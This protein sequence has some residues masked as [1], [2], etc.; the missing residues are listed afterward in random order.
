MTSHAL[1]AERIKSSATVISWL[2]IITLFAVGLAKLGL[3]DPVELQIA[4]AARQW[5]KGSGIGVGRDGFYAFILSYFF[6]WF[7]TIPLSGRLFSLCSALLTVA[8]GWQL[9]RRAISPRAGLYSAIVLATSPSFL[10]SGRLVGGFAP[11]FCISLWIGTASYIAFGH[12]PGSEQLPRLNQRIFGIILLAFG[13]LA[14]LISFGAMLLAVPAIGAVVIATWLQGNAKFHPHSLSQN[15]FLLLG[16]AL[17]TYLVI[18]IGIDIGVRSSDAS[19]FVGGVPRSVSLTTFETVI[20][21]WFH[22]FGPWSALLPWV[23]FPVVG[24]DTQSVRRSVFR[25]IMLV[26]LALSYAT[27]TL[28]VSGFGPVPPL[29]L[30]P[31]AFLVGESMDRDASIKGQRRAPLLLSVLILGLVFRDYALFADSLLKSL[32]LETV[33]VP[34]TFNPRLGWLVSSACFGMTLVTISVARA[35]IIQTDSTLARM[36]TLLAT[37][38]NRGRGFQIWMIALT[39]LVLAIVLGAFVGIT[40][41]RVLRFNSLVTKALI[42][43]SAAIVSF[44]VFV[45]LFSI[46]VRQVRKLGDH[47]WTPL[48]VCGFAF[49]GYV[50]YGFHS[51]LS[52]AMSGQKVF[53]DVNRVASDGEPIGAYHTNA[54]A[55]DYYIRTPVQVLMNEQAFMDFL[56]TDKRAWVIFPRAELGKL[57]RLFRIKTSR[58]LFTLSDMT[59]QTLFAT[60]HAPKTGEN[61]NMLSRCIVDVVPKMQVP[62]NISWNEGIELLGY[63]LYLPHNNSVGPGESFDIEWVYRSNQDGHGSWRPFVHIDGPSQRING[64]H[65]PVDGLYPVSN[66]RNGDIVLDRQTIRILPMSSPGTYDIF[67]G[68]YSGDSRLKVTKGQPK[69]ENRVRVGVLTIR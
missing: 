31:L 20:E 44:P 21:K 34:P 49:G 46:L 65:D 57:D 58:H 56:E 23:V 2:A 17:L 12:T 62:V 22:G 30:M 7:G 52:N 1:G 5:S 26:Y 3:W 40:F 37:Q 4:D 27:S 18:Q 24:E 55:A 50:A 16:T 45:V 60:N 36:K 51:A 39:G 19:L 68:F 61:T 6:T 13:L 11:A 35:D 54:R 64:D 42:A 32:G 41:G 38:W 43:A 67:T 48:V 63:T 53:V 59:S 25:L 14:A 10:L 47:I 9:V 15:K 28:F 66:W 29:G 33:S 69:D 8:L